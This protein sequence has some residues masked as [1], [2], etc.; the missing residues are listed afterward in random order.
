MSLTGIFFVNCET[1][2]SGLDIRIKKIEITWLP[3]RGPE[4]I[5]GRKQICIM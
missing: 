2:E 5:N 4:F 1:Q 3:H